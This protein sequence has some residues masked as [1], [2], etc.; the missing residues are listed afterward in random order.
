MLGG[1]LRGAF[2]VNLPMRNDGQGLT[3]PVGRSTTKFH[4]TAALGELGK[5]KP[6]Q[7]PKNVVPRQ[8]EELRHQAT[9]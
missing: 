6:A 7:D 2:L 9:A 5:A 8:R 4:V 1:I 3:A